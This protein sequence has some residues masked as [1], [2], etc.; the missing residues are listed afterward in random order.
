MR[1]ILDIDGDTVNMI[2]QPAHPASLQSTSASSAH[3]APPPE[4]LQAA[5]A[6]GAHDAG[7]A[8][9]HLAGLAKAVSTADWNATAGTTNAGSAPGSAGKNPPILKAAAGVRVRSKKRRS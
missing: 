5:A 1:I 2:T 7:P 8:P 6:S 4:L 3:S 9:L